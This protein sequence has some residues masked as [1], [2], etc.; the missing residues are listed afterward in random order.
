MKAM[1]TQAEDN[2]VSSLYVRN[3]ELKKKSILHESYLHC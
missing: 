3:P 1:Q 2:A